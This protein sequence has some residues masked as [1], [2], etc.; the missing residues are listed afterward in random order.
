M[1][2]FLVDFSKIEVVLIDGDSLFKDSF[3]TM[4]NY[5]SQVF[6]RLSEH[7]KE[8]LFYS[9]ESKPLNTNGLPINLITKE[10]LPN[11]EVD[12]DSCM[13]IA[14]GEEHPFLFD[15]GSIV[16]STEPTKNPIVTAVAKNKEQETVAAF[17]DHALL[18][19]FYYSI[20]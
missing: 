17:L 15:Y 6:S 4:S 1:S 10:E 12:P 2:N 16:I 14:K 18:K 19:G 13:V 3:P 7:K 9:E 20:A 5:T 11:F 8:I